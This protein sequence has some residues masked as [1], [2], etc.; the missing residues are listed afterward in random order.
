VVPVDEIPDFA[1]ITKLA[2]DPRGTGA[3]VGVDVVDVGLTDAVGAV[4][5]VCVV[6]AVGAVVD[7]RVVVDV[8]VCAGVVTAVS[9]VGV[10]VAPVQADTSVKASIKMRDTASPSMFLFFI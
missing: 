6:V 3:N 10:V 2:A 8:G 1:R 4:V 9:G 7:V 5:D